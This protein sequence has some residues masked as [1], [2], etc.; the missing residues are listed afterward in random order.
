MNAGRVDQVG[1]IADLAAHPA[2]RA[3]DHLGEQSG[4]HLRRS[5]RIG[6]GQRRARHRMSAHMVKPRRMALQPAGNLTQAGGA[7]QLAVQKR[8]QLVLGGQPTN[9]FVRPM[10][11]DQTLER[12]P[13][14]VL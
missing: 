11:R 1:R 4:K 14:N 7:R 2:P 3:P 10:R 6:V 9:V 13:G 12:S 8:D 5:T